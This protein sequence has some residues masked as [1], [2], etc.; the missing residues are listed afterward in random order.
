M[1]LQKAFAYGRRAPFLARGVVMGPLQNEDKDR[2]RARSVVKLEMYAGF[3]SDALA[4]FLSAIRQA[5]AQAG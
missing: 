2:F 5:Q 1:D 4:P 3:S